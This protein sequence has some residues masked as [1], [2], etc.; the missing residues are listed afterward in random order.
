MA[1]ST[2]CPGP[3]PRWANRRGERFVTAAGQLVPHQRQEAPTAGSRDDSPLLLSQP[4][5]ALQQDED[6][7]EGANNDPD[8]PRAEAAVER[9]QRRDHAE[10]EDTEQGAQGVP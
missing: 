1:V 3:G 9:D 2:Y 7:Q 5:Q 8:P 4:H 6:K 10:N